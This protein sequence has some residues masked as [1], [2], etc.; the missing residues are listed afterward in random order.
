MV[1]KGCNQE[2]VNR[3]LE[4]YEHR[5]RVN[6]EPCR[7]TGSELLKIMKMSDFESIFKRMRDNE[8]TQ[9]KFAEIE[10]KI[11]TI[12]NFNDFF[13]ILLNEISQV[14]EIPYVWLSVIENSPLAD[15]VNRVRDCQ[16]IESQTR[17]VKQ[18]EFS[19]YLGSAATPQLVNTYLSPYS[20]FFPRNR[21]YPLRSMALVPL[22]LDRKIVG[23]L[24][25][26]D[27]TSTRFDPHQD[28]SL[29]E[30][31]MTKVSLCLSNVAAHE[32][33]NFFAYHDPL[34]GLIN[35]RSFETALHREFGRAQRHSKDL[36]V[37]FIDLDGFKQIN[38]EHGHE[39]GDK[40]LQFVAGKLE[41]MSR[42]EDIVSRFAGDEFVVLLPETQAEASENMIRR[43]RDSL[44]QK[45]MQYQGREVKISLSYGIAG[46]E[47]IQQ[48]RPDALL[49]HADDRLGVFKASR[50]K[51]TEMPLTP[52]P[53][54]RQARAS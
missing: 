53:R 43:V 1:K 24:N 28:T 54:F 23:S 22:C 49:K 30:Q 34:T 11:L 46:M 26:G 31:F 20:V 4:A 48:S 44:E 9:R 12:L 51:N 33:L 8:E 37:I 7:M 40:A 18:R 32:R 21:H 27:Y 10:S 42:K 25:M 19:R 2:K 39:C 14:F 3:F 6:G 41:S 47:E 50:I 36:S 5:K 17:F 45:P 29:F 35:R 13:E 52:H 38:E 16:C 15:L